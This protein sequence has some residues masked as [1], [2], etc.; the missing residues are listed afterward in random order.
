[1]EVKQIY[2]FANNATKE[3]IGETGLILE[4]LSNIVDV[5]NAVFNAGAVD[6]YVK[7]LVNH[8]GRVIFVDR[9]YRG[10]APS[11]L[12]EAWEFGSVLEKIQAEI[13][14]AREN[15]AWEL[16]DGQSYDPNIFYK[17]TVTAKFYNSK[18]TFEIPMSI[19]ER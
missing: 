10:H 14:E 17:P 4:D 19:T 3:A 5:G 7:S 8:I 15:Q 16:T 2:T 6:K 11:V 9:I 18:T 13:P 1:M 12:R